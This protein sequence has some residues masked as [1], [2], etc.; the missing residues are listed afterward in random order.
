[1]HL[2]AWGSPPIGQAT[3]PRATRTPQAVKH[4]RLLTAPPPGPRPTLSA[5]TTSSPVLPPTLPHLVAATAGNAAH[6]TTFDLCD[7]TAGPTYRHA[8]AGRL[9]THRRRQPRRTLA[10]RTATRAS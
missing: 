1:M 4:H 9:C 3:P 7:A 10:A 8:V 6:A 2:I 5:Q